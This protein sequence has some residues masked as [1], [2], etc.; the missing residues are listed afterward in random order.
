MCIVSMVMDGA[1]TVPIEQWDQPKLDQLFITV[2]SARKL[3]ALTGQPDCEDPKKA[4][5]LKRIT[6]RV[7]AKAMAA[8]MSLVG[9]EAD[10]FVLGAEWACD[11]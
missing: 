9:I 5:F 2:E 6:T 3:D 4:A 8:E 7:A 10:A 1:R 11:R